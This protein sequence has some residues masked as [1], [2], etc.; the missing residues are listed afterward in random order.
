MIGTIDGFCEELLKDDC[1]EARLEPE[2]LAED[3]SRYFEVR[4]RLSVDDIAVLLENA[5]IGVVSGARLARGLRGVHYIQP[6]ERYAIHYL[7][8]QWEGGK[9]HTVLH[10]TYEIV[11]EQ[12]WYRRFGS[13]LNSRVCTEADRFAAA[14]MMPP[15]T[16]EAYALASGL[17]VLALQRVFRCAY[18]SATRRLGEVMHRQ[19]LMAVLYERRGDKSEEWTELADPGEFRATAVVRTPGFEDESSLLLCGTRGHTPLPFR[20]P[21]PGSLAERM[22]HEG[23]AEY[24]E[25]EPWRDEGGKDGLAIAAKPV[26]WQGKL[27]KVAVVAVPYEDRSVLQR[28]EAQVR[29]HPMTAVPTWT[30][31]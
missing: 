15:D 2:G 31:R 12:V 3:F 23:Q 14:V 4:L 18:Y 20:R 21:S 1:P 17:D 11:H 22:I 5:G 8:S 10:E 24:A 26:V 25:V 27:A 28:Q 30:A 19:P 9:V 6:D 16:F 13:P 7:E 29:R